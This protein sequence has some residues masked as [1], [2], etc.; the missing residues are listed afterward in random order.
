MPIPLIPK[1]L[2]SPESKIQYTIAWKVAKSLPETFNTIVY[3]GENPPGETRAAYRVIVAH[4]RSRSSRESRTPYTERETLNYKLTLEL[5][6]L[7]QE[8]IST[9]F[10]SLIKRDLRG[11]MPIIGPILEPLG[12]TGA[13]FGSHSQADGT[14]IWTIDT[15]VVIRR[16]QG[17]IFELLPEVANE[18]GL[19]GGEL[20]PLPEGFV[21]ESFHFGIFR[22]PIPGLNRD[23]ASLDR[24]L[25]VETDL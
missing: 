14:W 25:I 18:I 16:S 1:Q 19:G 3:S 11:F 8:T 10:T 23:D 17:E 22:S 7:T 24:E 6:N 21:L 5:K 9:D 2:N 13:D 20:Y 15:S 12:V 4:P